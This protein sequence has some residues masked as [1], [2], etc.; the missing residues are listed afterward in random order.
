[1]AFVKSLQAGS[2]EQQCGEPGDGMACHVW[3]SQPFEAAL[4]AGLVP[5]GD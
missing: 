1:M 4:I 5:R 3:L 2:K